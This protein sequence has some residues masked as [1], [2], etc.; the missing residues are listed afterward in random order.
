MRAKTKKDLILQLIIVAIILPLIIWW[1]PT[2]QYRVIIKWGAIALSSVLYFVLNN[3]WK[4]KEADED[5]QPLWYEKQKTKD[6]EKLTGPKQVEKEPMASKSSESE[7]VLSA[8]QI[9]AINKRDRLSNRLIIVILVALAALMGIGIV[10]VSKRTDVKTGNQ[11]YINNEATTQSQAAQ[12]E[13]RDGTYTYKGEWKGQ[14][15]PQECLLEFTVTDGKLS[16]ALYTNVNYNVS[17]PLL[18]QI[19]GK[20]MIF[21]DMSGGEKLMLDLSFPYESPSYIEGYGMDYE[22]ENSTSQLILRR[23]FKIKR[24]S[25]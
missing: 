14:G 12:G 4:W 24:I 2:G 19:E 25:R 11:V 10:M 13:P 8:A 9:E 18:G 16:N 6:E 21:K 1:H 23:V 20:R 17:I 5:E 22:H 7:V 3:L 15:I